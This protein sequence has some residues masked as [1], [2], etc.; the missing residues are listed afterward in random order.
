KVKPVHGFCTQAASAIVI[1]TAALLGGPVSSTQVIGS[2]L[3]GVGSAERVNMVRW[4]VAGQIAIA[5]LLTIPASA[6][7]AAMLYL[8]VHGLL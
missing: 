3:L 1:L 8:A 7:I 4:N 2:T 5:W 6:A